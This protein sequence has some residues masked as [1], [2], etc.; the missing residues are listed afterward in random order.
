[1]HGSSSSLAV[2]RLLL[3]GLYC[4]RLSRG[5]RSAHQ[6]FSCLAAKGTNVIRED[7]GLARRLVP[8]TSAA[9]MLI[10]GTCGSLAAAQTP[11]KPKEEPAEVRAAQDIVIVGERRSA[12]KNVDPLATLDSNAIAATG[13]TTVG[14][15][16]KVIKP[17]TQSADGR[18]PIFL[19]NGQRTSGYE[20]IGSLPPEAIDKV[21]VLPEPAALRYGYP[22]TRRVLNFITKRNFRQF[23]ARG[24]IGTTT[25]PGSTTANANLN[26]TRLHKDSRFTLALES[27]HTSSLLQSE[28]HILPDPDVLFDG[29]GNVTSPDFG[30]IDPALSAA[31]GQIITVAPVPEDEADRSSLAA[32]AAAGNQPRLFDLGPYR[33]LVPRNDAWKAEAVFADKLGGTLSGSLNLTA[34]QSTD[35]TLGALAAAT[36]TVPASN[37]YSPF[38]GTVLLH[39]YLTEVDPLRSRQTTT[40]VHGG[41]TLRGVTAG[42]RWDLT[43][44]F[45]QKLIKGVGELGID[46]SAANAAIAAGANPFAPLDPSL[47]ADRLTTRGRLLTRTTGSKLVVTN[48]P[49]ELPAGA[50]TVTGT[51]EGERLSANSVTRGANPF[52]LR[53][54]RTHTEAGISLDIPLTS[55][56]NKFLAPVGDLSVNASANARRVGGF[57]ALYD[58]TIGLAWSPIKGVQLLLQDKSSGAAP[59]MEKLATPII[60]TPNATVFDFVTGRTEIVTLTTGGNPDLPAEHRHVRSFTLNVKPFPN[61][62]IRV[63]GTFEDTDIRDQTGDIYALTPQI[64]DIFPDRFVRDSTG[65]LVAV[66]FQPTNFHRERQRTLNLTIS[67]NGAVGRKPPAGK[68]G[69]PPKDNR[70]YYYAGAGPAIRF[71]DRLELRP[72]TSVLDLLRGDTVT[73]GGTPR[74]TSYFYGGI[75]YLG[76]GANIDGWYQS[77]NRVRSDN[78]SSDLFFAPFFKVN[79][80]VFVSVHHFLP[81]E[82]WTRHTQLKLE[83]GNVTDARPRV[84]DRNGREP[85]R[86]Q[87]DFLDPIGR[88]VK[89]TLR[90]T[91]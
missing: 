55:R 48:T 28:R 26:F 17:L 68:S 84:H 8:A 27:R 50:V 63:S 91:L 82:E 78:P 46:I 23:E 1:M 85:Y 60:V 22:P 3:I 12:V 72:G 24:S 51:V 49:V 37:P 11:K 2:K 86:L 16:L 13:A 14:E 87:P 30:E 59:A 44:A 69:E 45:D 73:G 75:G 83:L 32:Y 76:N 31:A 15:L 66:T 42:W 74:V 88:T 65:R 36:L 7:R 52:D 29:I 6:L 25:R 67:A 61:R 56:A 33:T 43:A 4:R 70:P 57:G 9:A 89:L 79:V 62:D 53:L 80:G 20:E 5:A 34:E 58:H 35:R 71:S 38:S 54:G 18:D 21:E 47:L 40:T 81:K 39:R 41:S 64:E 10:A 77:S 90:K 19:L